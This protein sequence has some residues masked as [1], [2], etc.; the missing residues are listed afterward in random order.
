MRLASHHYLSFEILFNNKKKG[1]VTANG[2]SAKLDSNHLCYTALIVLESN[3]NPS[4]REASGAKICT[5]VRF[6]S[7]FSYTF[8]IILPLLGLARLL[9]SVK[10]IKLV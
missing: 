7:N 5:P 10:Y 9:P 3:R 4:C 2:S 1:R 6:P 8:C